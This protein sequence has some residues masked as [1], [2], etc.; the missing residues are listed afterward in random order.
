MDQDYL[1]SSKS[2]DLLKRFVTLV[3]PGVAT[4]YV[5]LSALWDWPNAEAVAGS[6]AAIATFGGVLMRVATKSYD[7]SEAKY[8]GELITKGYDEDTGIPSLELNISGDPRVLASKSEV[9][10]RSVNEA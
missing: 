4:L 10:L 5:T 2:Y 8:D 1:I 7:S 6:L 3:L 9:V